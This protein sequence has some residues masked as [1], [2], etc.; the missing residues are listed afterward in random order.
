MILDLDE[1]IFP[2]FNGFP[3]EGIKFLERLKKNNNREWYAKHKQEYEE[4]LKFPMQCFV[5]SL[6][7]FFSEFAPQYDVHPKHSVFRIYRDVRFSKN[8]APYKTH[9]AAHFVM[10]GNPK[11]FLGSGYYMSIEPGEVFL[12]GG[13]YM[14][15]SGQLKK[16]RK[17]IDSRSKEFL[18]ILTKK[19]FKKMFGAIEGKTLQRI[20]QGFTSDHPLA[21][22]LKLKQFFVG[23]ELP[24]TACFK[25][26]FLNKAEEVFREMSPFINFLN[27]ALEQ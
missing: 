13:I 26:N 11:G 18:E 22:Y 4:L 16:I 21:E 6:K 5:N 17:A 19:S 15:E 8:K 7:P 3:N 10:R 9:I 12:G 23:V 20:P 27:E 14:P 25:K 2:P 1:Q 24:E